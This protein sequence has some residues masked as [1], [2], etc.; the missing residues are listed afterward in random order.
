MLHP[1]MSLLAKTVFQNTKVMIRHKNI[2]E[3]FNVL[4]CAIKPIIFGSKKRN[5][6]KR[7]PWPKKITWLQSLDFVSKAETWVRN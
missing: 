2:S 6:I 5:A 7:E 1:N 3:Q 4:A